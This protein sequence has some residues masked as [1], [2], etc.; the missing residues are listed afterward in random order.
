[1]RRLF[2]LLFI[3]LLLTGGCLSSFAIR[4]GD[5]G[6]NLPDVTDI[7]P[8]E[9]LDFLD[10]FK[11]QR[12]QADFILHFNLKHLKRQKAGHTY[13]GTLW[14]SWNELGQVIR[15]RI[16]LSPDNT[17]EGIAQ[18]GAHP[19]MWVLD[20]HHQLKE[21]PEEA[22]WQPIADGLLYRPIDLLLGFIHWPGITYEG[23]ER[24]KGRPAHIYF[25]KPGKNIPD[26]SIAGVRLVIDSVYHAPIKADWINT[27][28]NT[29][30]AF[31][32]IDFKKVGDEWLI[33]TID[34]VDTTTGEKTRFQVTDAQTGLVLDRGVFY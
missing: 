3:W 32:V 25:L 24:V 33:K 27:Q 13:T 11:H 10:T 20:D 6:M 28:G 29:T 18:S 21:L 22:L 17:L 7:S 1:M 12:T 5:R 23:S 15:F 14:G 9:A 16:Q 2:R 8:D 19:R 34:F 30:Y 26:P 31:K 4:P